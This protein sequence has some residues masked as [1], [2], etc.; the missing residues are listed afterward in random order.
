MRKIIELLEE[1]RDGEFFGIPAEKIRPWLNL[2]LKDRRVKNFGEK[3]VMKTFRFKP[4]TIAK[5]AKL[6]KTMKKSE[7]EI[8][9]SLVS[10]AAQWISRPIF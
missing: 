7:T 1:K 3:K 10:R 4:E 9:E 6:K 5:I 2:R 8:L